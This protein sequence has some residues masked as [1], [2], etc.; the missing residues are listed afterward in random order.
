MKTSY[1]LHILN[2]L[3][4]TVFAVNSFVLNSPGS[5]TAGHLYKSENAFGR[6]AVQQGSIT[7]LPLQS[8]LMMAKRQGGKKDNKKKVQ[9]TAAQPKPSTKEDVI[10]V[11]GVVKESLPNAMFRVELEANQ[12][13]ILCTISGK[14]RK[15][16]VKVLVGDSVR[17][18]L[19][20]YDLTR[21]RITFRYRK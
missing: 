7:G 3:I 11:E 21:G 4:F 20:P 1:G 6:V 5:K 19:S 15:N 13:V 12:N 16:F 10:E 9:Q 17:V 18:E 14:I 8:P 2:F